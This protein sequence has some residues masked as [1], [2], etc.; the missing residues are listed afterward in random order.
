MNQKEERQVKMLEKIADDYEANIRY[1]SNGANKAKQYHEWFESF[2]KQTDCDLTQ[3]LE[4]DVCEYQIKFDFN[5]MRKL[6]YIRKTL[7]MIMPKYKDRLDGIYHEHGKAVVGYM[8]VDAPVDIK[9]RLIVPIGQLP[10]IYTK[11]GKC[12][13]KTRT[14]KQESKI[15]EFV[16][17]KDKK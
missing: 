6:H 7:K 12:G 10:K 14:I 9:Y 2:M 17:Q 1:Y 11:G 4:V 5:S 13:F 3:F 8:S 15:T 16:C